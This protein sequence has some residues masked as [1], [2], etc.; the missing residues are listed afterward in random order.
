MN[1]SRVNK[2]QW[3]EMFRII[4]LDDSTM[5]QW[6]RVFEQLNPEG[7]QAFLEW[8]DIPSSEIKEI[9]SI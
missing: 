6:H 8:L 4:G 2:E 3:V 9:R 1:S 5:N 7:H